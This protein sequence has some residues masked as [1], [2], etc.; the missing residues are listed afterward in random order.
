MAS[1]S[2]ICTRPKRG[3]C[4]I[5]RRRSQSWSAAIELHDTPIEGESVNKE[6]GCGLLLYCERFVSRGRPAWPIPPRENQAAAGR[7]R[8]DSD[9]AD[10]PPIP[11]SAAAPSHRSLAAIGRGRSPHLPAAPAAARCRRRRS[12]RR[13]GRLYRGCANYL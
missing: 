5:W 6:A 8:R 4:W 12:Q 1:S 7:A 2:K 9:S 10:T 11:A 13:G 3:V